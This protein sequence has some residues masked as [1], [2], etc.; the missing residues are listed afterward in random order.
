MS[1]ENYIGDMTCL[2]WDGEE[3]DAWKPPKARCRV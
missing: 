3:L 1:I 2:K